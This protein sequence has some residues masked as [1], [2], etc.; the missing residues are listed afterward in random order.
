MIQLPAIVLAAGQSSRMGAPKQLLMYQG[1]TL[2]QHAI[3]L[4]EEAQF[5]PIVVVLGAFYDQIAPTLEGLPVEVVWNPDWKAGM[6][7][8]VRTGFQHVQQLTP[9]APACLTMLSDQPL[10]TAKHLQN[11]AEA[12][13]N[14]AYPI[15]ATRYGEVKGVPI[16]WDA[17]FYPVLS[18]LTGEIG[19]RKLLKQ[20]A[21]Q[22]YALPYEPAG[23]DVD[24]PEDYHDLE[25]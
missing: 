15:I 6:G 9:Q 1:K 5:T 23:K 16:V 25:G 18:Q 2:L 14:A 20:Y 21:S 8:S 4:A 10:L 19:A 24:T 11:L 17:Q 7:T 3:Y 13:E 22:V 12:W